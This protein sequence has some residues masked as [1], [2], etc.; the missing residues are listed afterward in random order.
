MDG[1]Y[2][3]GDSLN[4]SLR[5]LFPRSLY[6]GPGASEPERAVADGLDRGVAPDCSMVITGWDGP[7]PV[8]SFCPEGS[9]FSWNYA[10][11]LS[12]AAHGTP[13]FPNGRCEID[14]EVRVAWM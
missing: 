11:P 4:I 3:G 14:L 1:G 10:I 8:R 9:T 7:R 12:K 13:Y 6:L 5:A 2:G